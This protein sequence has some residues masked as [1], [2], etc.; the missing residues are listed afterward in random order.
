[1]SSKV[2]IVEDDQGL[3]RAIGYALEREGYEVIT[4]ESGAE[5]L[6]KV[7][8]ENPDLVILDIMLPGMS[9]LEV[10]REL[11][12]KPKTV[13]LP[14]IMLSA[15]TKVSDRVK[16][17]KV[18][19]DDYVTKPF[20]LDELIARVAALLERTRRL[21]TGPAV[22]R[23]RVLGFL[24]AKGGVGT[25]TIAVNVALALAQRRNRVIAVELRPYFGTMALQLGSKPHAH[26]AG[27]LELPAGEVNDRQLTR[28]LTAYSSDLRVLLGPQK[29]AEYREVE[30][31]QAGA[32][33]TSLSA[34]AAYVVI[35]LPCQPSE[36]V[37]AALRCCDCAVV[38]V[39]PKSACVKAA[40]LTIELLQ[41]WGISLGDVR[42]VVVNRAPMAT[43]MSIARISE[44]LGCEILGAVA[45]TTDLAM[46][47]IQLGQP[48]V[49][50]APDSMAAL[51]LGR[52]AER[53][54]AH[55]S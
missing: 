52:I 40:G 47:A 17:L 7:E 22:K 15:L 3:L 23:G 18:G 1:M 38:V 12:S 45:H 27:W 28:Y 16:G 13:S 42:V 50:S 29:V 9:G 48:L 55:L 33:I 25:T 32:V 26:A 6:R 34:M 51:A 8:A 43:P 21:R 20:H 35:D 54:A 39:E 31:D 14:V 30:A 10:C 4:A 11:R 37:R 19:A 41:T 49:V 53:L 36:A 44:T 24:G 2:L 5:A 46:R